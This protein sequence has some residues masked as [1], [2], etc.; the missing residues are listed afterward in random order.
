VPT[1]KFDNIIMV[2][3]HYLRF[4]PEWHTFGVRDGEWYRLDVKLGE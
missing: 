2:R 1:E 4:P 3:P